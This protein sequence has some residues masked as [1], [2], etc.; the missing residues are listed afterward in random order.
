MGGSRHGWGL[1]LEQTGYPITYLMKNLFNIKCICVIVSDNTHKAL[2]HILE[3]RY[4]NIRWGGGRL[5]S[6]WKNTLEDRN[7]SEVSGNIMIN[8]WPYC[9]L[10]TD[11]EKSFPAL[12]NTN[13]KTDSFFIADAVVCSYTS[14]SILPS[15]ILYIWYLQYSCW[16][17]W[18]GYRRKCKQTSNKHAEEHYMIVHIRSWLWGALM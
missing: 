11:S 9:L 13:M 3:K 10:K 14:W 6:V 15:K 2:V 7:Y 12:H 1:L 18:I 5:Q 8:W 16:P 4:I 17:S